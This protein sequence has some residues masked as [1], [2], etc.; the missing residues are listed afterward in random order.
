MA[1]LSAGRSK[2][3]RGRNGTYLGGKYSQ[4]MEAVSSKSNLSPWQFTEELTL[5]T[6]REVQKG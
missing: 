4:R 6:Q 2:E 5:E 1:A 3:Y